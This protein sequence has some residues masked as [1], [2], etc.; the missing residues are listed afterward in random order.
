[1]ADSR[2]IAENSSVRRKTTNLVLNTFK[3]GLYV[4]TR[5]ND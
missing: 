3:R 1:M 4:D 2:L 5:S